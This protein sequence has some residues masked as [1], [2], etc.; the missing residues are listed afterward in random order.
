[1]PCF[2]CIAYVNFCADWDGLHD[3]LRDISWQDILN[4]SAT[5]AASELCELFRVGID[6]YIPHF[7]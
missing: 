2:Y 6:V 1:M 5:A 3:Q 7:K 4:L